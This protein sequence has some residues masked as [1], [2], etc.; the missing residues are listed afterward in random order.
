MGLP[1]RFLRAIARA[2]VCSFWFLVDVASIAPMGIEIAPIVAPNLD[3][4]RGVG[5]LACAPSGCWKTRTIKLRGG[6]C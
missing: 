3:P 2:Y 5:A 4:A 1:Y 6:R